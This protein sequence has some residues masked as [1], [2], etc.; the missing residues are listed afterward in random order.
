MR[1]SDHVVRVLH[2]LPLCTAADLAALCDLPLVTLQEELRR[3][4]AAGWV[5]RLNLTDP[6][7]E[8]LEPREPV[9]VISEAA[10]RVML[11][12]PGRAE[13]DFGPLARWQLRP[14]SVPDAISAAPLVRAGIAC[15]A[16]LARTIAREEDG[17]LAWAT[18]SPPPRAANPRR[19]PDAALQWGHYEG[20]WRLDE[21]DAARDARFAIHVDRARVPQ[22]RRELWVRRWY[23][24]GERQRP[25][26]RL[27]PLLVLCETEQ[28]EERWDELYR[29]EMERRGFSGYP[30]IVTALIE[31]ATG[32]WGLD[33]RIW[34]QARPGS[35]TDLVELRKL[36][37]LQ[38]ASPGESP[39][40]RG[41]E[42]LRQL[43][44][45][46]TSRQQLFTNRGGGRP[47][48]RRATLSLSLTR[49]QHQVIELLAR[50]PWLSARDL[51]RICDVSY[52]RSDRECRSMPADAV[53]TSHAHDGERRY[54]L[55][56]T[57]VELTAARAGMGGE[58]D[59]YAGWNAVSW[60]RPDEPAP[61]PTAHRI[62]VNRVMG[63]LVQR[64]RA[65]EMDVSRTW[66]TEHDWR[67]S[68]GNKP[69]IPDGGCT[70]WVGE[71]DDSRCAILVEYERPERGSTRLTEKLN[72]W[73]RW[74]RRWPGRPPLLLVVWDETSSRPGSPA[75]AIRAM[76][77]PA[78]GMPE[79]PVLGASVSDLEDGGYSAACWLRPDGAQV[80]IEA[81]LRAL[82]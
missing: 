52:E 32:Q 48:Q 18:A 73:N 56:K 24:L 63:L 8:P 58:R 17:R 4:V 40:D 38:P 54:L 64:A 33:D 66:I 30:V 47:P 15:L 60:A 41:D 9:W 20:R 25:A 65:V 31:A 79:L 77:P 68:Q 1:Y 67:V 14:R 23:Q 12:D 50:H 21:D 75:H 51:G 78:P 80:S 81:A 3:L 5:V 26:V 22:R 7:C 35:R 70:V 13:A 44:D 72:G 27:T 53:V 59:R 28:G 10:R 6:G 39:I 55:T 11:A 46:A 76:H 49:Y 34:R 74:Y 61:T 42:P 37:R 16:Q 43:A 29:R 45:R 69:P 71:D 36:L 19:D 57:S 2:R 82:A 62:G